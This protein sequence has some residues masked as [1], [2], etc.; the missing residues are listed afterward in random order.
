MSYHLYIQIHDNSLLPFYNKSIYKLYE[1][2]YSQ[3][4][5]SGFD[6]F[7]PNS[8]DTSHFTGGKPLK[9]DHK[10]SCAMYKHTL[11]DDELTIIEPCGYYLYPRSSISK[12]P[13]RL[14][15]TVG[16]IDSGYRGNL[17]AKIDCLYKDSG[18]LENSVDIGD[19]LFQICT[20]DLSPLSS[21][22]IV[23]NLDETQRG[24]GGFGSTGK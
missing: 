13:Y 20:P 14:A 4:R 17:M 12:T 1:G 21:V 2:I 6:L 11:V 10:V 16:I 8:F 15:N 7:V 9:V 5:D 3:H 23:D 18:E 19:R 22:K 24:C